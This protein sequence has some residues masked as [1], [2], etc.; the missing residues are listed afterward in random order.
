MICYLASIMRWMENE[1]KEKTNNIFFVSVCGGGWSNILISIISR[2]MVL[3]NCVWHQ[4]I[5]NNTQYSN[6]QTFLTHISIV[7]SLYKYTECQ[8]KIFQLILTKWWS[9]ASKCK[10]SAINETEWD[11]FQMN[12]IILINPTSTIMI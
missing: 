8:G 4:I 3:I 6:I 2:R 9:K 11:F 1:L 12:P 5:C 7:I 10:Y